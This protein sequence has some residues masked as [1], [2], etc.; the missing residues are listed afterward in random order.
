LEFRLIELDNTS[1]INELMLTPLFLGFYCHS[2]VKL[3]I[4]PDHKLAR[5]RFFWIFSL[6]GTKIEIIFN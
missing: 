1:P 2:P 5:I 3:R 4:N 6:L